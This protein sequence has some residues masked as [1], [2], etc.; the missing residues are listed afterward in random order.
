M[1]AAGI[2][3]I[4]EKKKVVTVLFKAPDNWS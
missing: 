4:F 3:N 2:G 1:D